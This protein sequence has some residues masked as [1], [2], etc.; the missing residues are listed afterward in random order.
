LFRIPALTLAEAY[1]LGDDYEY[2]TAM[3]GAAAAVAGPRLARMMREDVA[4]LQDTGLERLGGAKESLR[5][6]YGAF[7]HPA[8]QEI[9]AWLDGAYRAAEEMAAS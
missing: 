8:A 5:A 6:R 7:D 9:L 1:R 4:L 2:A 3:E